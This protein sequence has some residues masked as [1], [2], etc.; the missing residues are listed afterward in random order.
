M[1][2]VEPPLMDMSFDDL[3]VFNFVD[4]G[5]YGDPISGI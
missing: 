3:D 5:A 1:L 2:D 4:F